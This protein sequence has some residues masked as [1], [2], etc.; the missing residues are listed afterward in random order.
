VVGVRLR[1][2]EDFDVLDVEAERGDARH[3]HAGGCRVACIEHDVALRPGDEEGRD[4]VRPNVVEVASYAKR[5]GGLLSANLCRIQPPGD[6]HQRHNA[7]DCQQGHQPATLGEV[8]Q[9]AFAS[10]SFRL[11]HV[12][13]RAWNLLE[14]HVE[15]LG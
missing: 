13:L 14:E 11:V 9:H 7:Q 2:D 8:R 3:D 6:E 10:E 4:V 12:G 5:F 15:R 1:V